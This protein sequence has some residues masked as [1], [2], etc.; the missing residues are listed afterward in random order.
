VTS[1]E[2]RNCYTFSVLGNNTP[3]YTNWEREVEPTQIAGE[4]NLPV[5]IRRH[6]FT[7]T[8]VIDGVEKLRASAAY[9]G[10]NKSLVIWAKNWPAIDA[11]QPIPVKKSSLLT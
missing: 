4:F 2:Q 1:L 11:I 7:E 5:P 9:Y 8:V 6:A 10:E 3:L